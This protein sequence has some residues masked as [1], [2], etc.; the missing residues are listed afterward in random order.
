MVAQ[1]L[2]AG[3]GSHARECAIHAHATL[4]GPHRW[5]TQVRTIVHYG[6][7]IEAHTGLEHTDER[8]RKIHKRAASVT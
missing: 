8:G 2:P 6:Q 3:V 4:C 7:N 1:V 5:P